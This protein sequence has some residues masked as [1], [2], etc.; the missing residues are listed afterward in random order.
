MTF[1]E[2]SA[3]QIVLD[4][5]IIRKTMQAL[6]EG[7]SS[8]GLVQDDRKQIDLRINP[9]ITFN[10]LQVDPPI[11]THINKERT[12]YSLIAKYWQ[13]YLIGLLIKINPHEKLNCLL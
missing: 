12:H 7:K 3:N 1:I 6:K 8:V 10:Q 9:D 5:S 4:P 13:I 11:V 2:L